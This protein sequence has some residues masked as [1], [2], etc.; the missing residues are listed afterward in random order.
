MRG[1][2]VTL[3]PS[4][5]LQLCAVTLYDKGHLAKRMITCIHIKLCL[6]S[7]P[8][9]GIHLRPD[10]RAASKCIKCSHV[11]MKKVRLS[12][13][14]LKDKGE[15]KC[16]QPWKWSYTIPKSARICENNEKNESRK[17]SFFY[18]SG[19]AIPSERISLAVYPISQNIGLLKSSANWCLAWLKCYDTSTNYL[20]PMSRSPQIKM[21]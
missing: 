11:R 21:A 6:K 4:K 20:P 18:K 10:T 13:V 16:M 9:S 14:N 17:P 12:A 5:T 19:Q 3:A 15:R 7:K 8:Q 2:A 1:L